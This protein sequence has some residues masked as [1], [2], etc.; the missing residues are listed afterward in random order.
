M[1]NNCCDNP[2]VTLLTRRN[3]ELVNRLC[4]RCKT[5]WYGRKGKVKEY[6]RKEWEQYINDI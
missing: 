5:H 1:V 4:L 2:A 3:D 6:T